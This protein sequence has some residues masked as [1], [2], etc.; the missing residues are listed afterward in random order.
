[1]AL[2]TDIEYQITGLTGLYED[3]IVYNDAID[4][5]DSNEKVFVISDTLLANSQKS[6]ETAIQ[7]LQQQKENTQKSY[8]FITQENTTLFNICFEKYGIVDDE[9]FET[10]I[11]ANDLMAFDRTDIDPLNPIIPKDT[12]ILYY[13]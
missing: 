11:D 12:L 13:K 9:K 4:I 3:F 2:L 8:E 5:T 7:E 6:Y 10:L 1:M